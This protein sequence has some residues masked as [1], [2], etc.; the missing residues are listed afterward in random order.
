MEIKVKTIVGGCVEGEVVVSRTPISF[1]GDVDLETSKIVARDSN[2]RNR[3]IA[4]KIL[5]IPRSRGSTVG[6][7]IIYAL[8]K[9]GLAPS[10][11][12]TVDPD[13]VIIVGCVISNIPL[14][15]GIPHKYLNTIKSG[16]H[17]YFDGD[18]GVLIIEKRNTHSY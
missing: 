6:S 5:I 8:Y 2:A 13:P 3:V 11:I 14:A 18:R 1:L 7:Y 17:A 15:I 16:Y 10:A 4:K 12:I 9:K